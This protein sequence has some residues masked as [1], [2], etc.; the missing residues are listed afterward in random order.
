MEEKAVN[1]L[2]RKQITFQMTNSK[3]VGKNNEVNTLFTLY[4][5]FLCK[6]FI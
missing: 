6:N 5:E 4:K 1:D 2:L 3:Q